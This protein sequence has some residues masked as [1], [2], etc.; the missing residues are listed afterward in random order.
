MKRKRFA[1][2]SI[3]LA[4][5]MIVSLFAV[6]NSPATVGGQA[7][8][9]A[10]PLAPNLV[11]ATMTGTGPAASTSFTTCET[12]IFAV[13]ANGALWYT[14][15]APSGNGTWNSVGGMCTSSPAVVSWNSSYFRVDVFVRGSDGA[16][17]WNYYQNGWYGWNSLGGQAASGTGPAVASWS[18]GRLDVFVPGY[19]RRPV[20]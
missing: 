15:M 9:T 11:N 19:G 12:E 18:A 6:V 8:G 20:A 4:T 17:W 16:I 5:L 1:M 2:S 10:A 13:D 7:S 14:S 3:A